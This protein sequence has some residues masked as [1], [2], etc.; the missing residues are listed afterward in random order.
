MRYF[1][2]DIGNSGIRVSELLV[3]ET[4]LANTVRLYWRHGPSAPTSPGIQSPPQERFDPERDDWTM[5]L[6]AFLSVEDSHWLVSSVRRDAR[7]TLERAIHQAC[8]GKCTILQHGDI[9][10][11]VDVDFPAKVGVDRLLAAYAASLYAQRESLDEPADQR[12]RAIVIQA[13]SAVTVDLIEWSREKTHFLGGAIVPGMPLMLRL[14]GQA[15]DLLPSLD[16]GDLE[17]MPDLPGKNTEAAMLCGT[18]SALVG[19]VQNLVQR[20]RN[21]Y[22]VASESQRDAVEDNT[23]PVIISGGDGP[24]IAGFVPE[25][26]VVIRDLVLDGLL[27][28]AIEMELRDDQD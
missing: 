20:Y 1:G 14:L 15:T 2:V 24:R 25:P 13:G 22:P 7:Q 6:D 4:R 27:S 16:S 26:S 28:L 10:L 23:L 21:I 9:P 3:G 11:E 8:H 19:G 5:Q 17:R 12:R 18:A